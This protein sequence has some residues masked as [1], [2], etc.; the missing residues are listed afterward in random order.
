[1]IGY[2]G[3][4]IRDQKGIET[5]MKIIINLYDKGNEIVF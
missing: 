1:M 4:S 5:R 3:M 2:S